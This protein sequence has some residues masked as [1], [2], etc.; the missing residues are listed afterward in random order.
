MPRDNIDIGTPIEHLVILDEDGNFDESLDPGLDDE[1]L[2][3]L[4]RVML[5][6]R[7]HDDRRLKWQRSGRIGT[8]APIKGQEAA[9]IGAVAALRDSDW[10]V[11]SFREVG[12]LIWRGASLVDLAI[13]DAGYNEGVV[14]PEGVRN[15]PNAVPVASQLTHAVGIAYGS[16]L[17]R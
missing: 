17:L 13:F 15:L 10:M 3:R 16:R 5:K 12:A 14:I 4:Y 8:F 6:A 9:Q 7:L 11:P 1:F 2:L